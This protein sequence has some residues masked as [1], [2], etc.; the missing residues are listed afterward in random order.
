VTAET[1]LGKAA[2][3]GAVRELIEK[4]YLIECDLYEKLTG[5]LFIEN[6]YGG[7]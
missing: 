1:G 5:Y 3:Q 7:E 2:Y 4:R 6:G